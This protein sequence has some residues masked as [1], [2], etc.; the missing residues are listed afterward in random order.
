MYLGTSIFLLPLHHPLMVAEYIRPWIIYP[1]G[2]VLF[3]VGQ[4]IETTRFNS[5]GIDKRD[6]RSRL[7]EGF[8]VIR[9]LWARKS[10]TFHVEHFHIDNA[11]SK[12]TPLW[13]S[14]A[15]QSSLN[16]NGT[17]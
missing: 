1:G 16:A 6:G 17:V 11:I 2:K 12:P 13:S 14:W 10:V 3:G 4:P 15:S 8:D 9:K 7:V 5:F